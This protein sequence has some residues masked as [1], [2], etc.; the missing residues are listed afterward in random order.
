MRSPIGSWP[1]SPATGMQLDL[2]PSEQLEDQ[3]AAHVSQDDFNGYTVAYEQ[4]E[5]QF[6]VYVLVFIGCAFGVAGFAVENAILVA[7]ALLALGFAYY[8]YPLLEYG[9]PRIG[10]GQYGIFVEGLGILAWKSVKQLDLTRVERR[11]VANHEMEIVLHEPLR[12]ALIADWRKR[13]L[14][15]F[16]M[17]LPWTLRGGDIVRI[18]LDILER[19]PDEIHHNFTRMLD[20]YRR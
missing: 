12:R 17:R 16:L 5:I 7:L 11:G 15:R 6:P 3:G 20:F 9:R 14:H 1:L 19:P 8:N 13:P 18:P 2:G 4:D 10:A